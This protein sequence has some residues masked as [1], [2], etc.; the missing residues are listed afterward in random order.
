MN[1]PYLFSLLMFIG[2]ILAQIVAWYFEFAGCWSPSSQEG[3][4]CKTYTFLAFWGVTLIFIPLGWWFFIKGEQKRVERGLNLLMVVNFVIGFI[5]TIFS[6]F[7]FIRGINPNF[8]GF[9]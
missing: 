9:I 7:N 6:L 5:L 3:L 2:Y 4:S 1:K 8:M